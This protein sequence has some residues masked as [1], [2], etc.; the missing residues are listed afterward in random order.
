MLHFCGL[1]KAREFNRSDSMTTQKLTFLVPPYATAT[2]ML[3]ELLTPDAFA[4]LESAV[5]EALREPRRDGGANANAP[6]AIEYD[7]WSTHLH[8]TRRAS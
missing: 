7:S 8:G 1:L 3:P 2:L 5:G 4:R 6:G